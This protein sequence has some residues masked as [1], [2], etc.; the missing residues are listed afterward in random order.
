VPTDTWIFP[1]L[2]SYDKTD[3]TAFRHIA[4]PEP[5]EPCYPAGY[6]ETYTLTHHLRE[7]INAQVDAAGTLRIWQQAATDTCEPAVVNC[8]GSTGGGA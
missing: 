3:P 6:N 2:L 1:L 7:K 8:G 5:F 4:C